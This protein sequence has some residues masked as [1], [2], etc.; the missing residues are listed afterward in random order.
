MPR[1]QEV[2][3][4]TGPKDESQILGLRLDNRAGRRGVGE[5]PF[6]APKAGGWDDSCLDAAAVTDSPAN[7]SAFGPAA[8]KCVT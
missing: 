5:V 8:P 6:P 7:T 1:D 4:G 3:S 2:N